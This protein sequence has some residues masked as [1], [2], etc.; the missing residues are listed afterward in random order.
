MAELVNVKTRA[1]RKSTRT[2]FS[3]EDDVKDEVK[4]ILAEF[5]PL[6]YWLMPSSS[7]YGTNKKHDFHL[8]LNGRGGTIET[9]FGSNKLSDGQN[10]C[11]HA[12]RGAGGFSF[13]INEKNI[14]GLKD[15]LKIA[16]NV[17]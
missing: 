8:I 5:G 12:V 11:F 7:A 2:T 1:P 3:G 13:V 16:C 15:A 14:A 6:C 17:K 10:E 4:R 9:K